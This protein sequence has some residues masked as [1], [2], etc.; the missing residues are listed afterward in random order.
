MCSMAWMELIVDED[1][2]ESSIH[3]NKRA[4]PVEINMRDIKDPA[5][6]SRVLERVGLQPDLNEL[7][8]L[9]SSF[10]TRNLSVTFN[11]ETNKV[12]VTSPC[13]EDLRELKSY[14]DRRHIAYTQRNL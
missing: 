9:E 13:N 12:S 5:T 6:R 10:D 4:Y 2:N 8:G 3:L 7:C 1:D 11:E 14:L